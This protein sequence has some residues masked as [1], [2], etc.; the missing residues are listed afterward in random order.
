LVFLVALLLSQGLLVSPGFVASAAAAAE[1]SDSGFVSDGWQIVVLQTVVAKSIPDYKIAEKKD[2]TNVLVLA[3]VTNTGSDGSL[4][5]DSFGVRASDDSDAGGLDL[6]TTTAASKTFGTS[7]I[8]ATGALP[9]LDSQ[10]RRLALVFSF[11]TKDGDASTVALGRA[12]QFLPLANTVT[13][14][15]NKVSLKEPASWTVAQASVQSVDG[16]GNL[17][18]GLLSGTSESVTL[19]GVTTPKSGACFGDESAQGIMSLTGGTVYIASDST[20]K[21]SNVWYF[22]QSVSHL[23]LLNDAVVSQ[24]FG[25]YLNTNPGLFGDWLQRESTTAKQAGT[26]LWALC[27]DAKGTWVN[28]PTESPEQVRSAYQEIDARDLIINPG[29]FEG[30]KIVV[31]GTVFNV[32]IDGG[33][34]FLQIWIDGGNYDAVV[35]GFLGETSGIYEGTYVTIYGEGKG[36]TTITNAYGAQIDQP[37]V[38]ADLIDH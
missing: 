14:K 37:L 7:E 16:G 11:S 20:A 28:P 12:G 38:K 15:I 31:R 30:K 25:G 17:T 10:T 22:D 23:V 32:Q 24:G 2:T 35:V 9:F 4:A 18:V 13:K 5:L 8:D 21:S 3:D 34:T 29:S 26:G 27:R 19:A 33:V 6:Q 36:S 1:S